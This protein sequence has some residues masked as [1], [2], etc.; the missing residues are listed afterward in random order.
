MTL[1]RRKSEDREVVDQRLD[2][3]EG[4]LRDLNERVLKVRKDMAPQV[5]R[6]H[7]AERYLIALRGP[8]P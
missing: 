2:A 7:L 6:N 3:A 8:T 4:M 1:W 5:A